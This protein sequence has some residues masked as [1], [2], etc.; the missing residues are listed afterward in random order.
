M[1]VQR[2]VILGTHWDPSSWL[3]ES[4]A[5]LHTYQSRRRYEPQNNDMNSQAV[6]NQNLTR[7]L[8]ETFWPILSFPRTDTPRAQQKSV[9]AVRTFVHPK[10]K[11]PFRKI[12]LLSQST[13]SEIWRRA[14]W[15]LL[16]RH[17]GRHD[18]GCCGI[19]AVIT[20]DLLLLVRNLRHL[21]EWLRLSSVWG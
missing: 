4:H 6:T 5:L 1:L 17:W 15:K 11:T 19:T 9:A 3:C 12:L 13:S 8:A 18:T 14:D 7:T 21:F 20:T 2:V 16:Y 10:Q